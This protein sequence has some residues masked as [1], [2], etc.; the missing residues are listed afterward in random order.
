M[1]RALKRLLVAVV[2]WRLLSP[3]IRPVFKPPQE[4]PWRLGGRTVFVGD[5]EFGVREIG[6]A[7]GRPLLLIH[8]LGGSSVSE[9]YQIAP[10]LA[11]ERRVILIDHRS[12][13]LSP[14]ANTRYEVED[15]ADDVAGVLDELGVGVVDVVGYSMGG[16]IAQAMAHRHPGR[17]ASLSLI[18]TFASYPDHLRWAARVGAIV[19]R[20]WERA[21]GLGTPEVRS[22][23]L[24]ATGAVE[25]RHGRWL[26]EET[27]RRDP[28]AG[29][30]ATL[31]LLRFDSRPWVARL[32]VPTLVMI[33]GHDQL[34]PPRWQYDMAGLIPGVKVVEIDGALHEV[35]WTHADRVTDELGVFLDSLT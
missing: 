35:V 19:T 14:S 33:P 30:Q 5:R 2:A 24:L 32:E 13:G 22:T 27:H 4:H 15:V 3:P 28:D 23:Y 1:K 17:V 8:G 25:R 18:A 34:V 20:A 11:T 26:W 21:T 10:K 16:V 29:A 9:W 7:T 12:H 6:P 31:A